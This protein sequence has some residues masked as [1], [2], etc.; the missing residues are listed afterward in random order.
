MGAAL[1]DRV[2]AF[3]HV[4]G[5]ICRDAANLLVLWDLAEQIGQYRR[6]ADV[7]L[8]HWL[9]RTGELSTAQIAS[10]FSSI[11]RW[12][13]YQTR[14]LGPPYSLA[15]HSPSFSMPVLSISMCSGP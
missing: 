3:A 12:N 9:F 4:K 5:A 1:S 7:A 10:V 15:C 13:L 2:V 6:I 8:I 11:P 14:R